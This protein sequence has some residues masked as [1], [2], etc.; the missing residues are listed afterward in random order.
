MVPP[1]AAPALAVRAL[2]LAFCA[3]MASSAMALEPTRLAG[4]W[5][6]SLDDT[7]RRCSL[8]LRVETADNGLA[9]GMPAG[10][11]RA[12]PILTNVDAWKV[13]GETVGFADRDG[14]TILTFAASRTDLYVARGPEGETYQ[15]A[16][17][18]TE[19]GF[20][21]NAPAN[22]PVNAAPKPQ[23][24]PTTTAQAPAAQAPA[25][26]GLT[27]SQ[28]P[29]AAPAPNAPVI[30][31]AVNTPV[32]QA[33]L[34]GRYAILRD[35]NKDTLCMLT[36]ES[37]ARGPRGTFKAQLAPACRDQGVVV[38][39]PMGWQLE[40]N[41]LVLTARKGHKATFELTADGSWQ[42]DPKE[43]G[44]PLGFRKL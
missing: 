39:E 24:L 19:G 6:M 30:A 37:A 31:P 12:L 17:A 29:A 13:Q 7:N 5:D 35:G 8:V 10:C 18:Q 44:R 28:A 34:V 2:P 1:F 23:P 38:F 26:S 20:R 42:K 15:L 33:D 3:L 40:R 27:R 11:R 14:E 32:K 25:P 21:Q 43:G 41:K 16:Q 4:G 36:L 9:L 22:R